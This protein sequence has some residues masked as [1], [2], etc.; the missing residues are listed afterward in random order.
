MASIVLFQARRTLPGYPPTQVFVTGPLSSSPR[1]H[2]QPRAMTS[3]ESAAT[4]ILKNDSYKVAGKK[5]TQ[6][7]FG[8]P[9]GIVGCAPS[10]GKWELLWGRL[11]GDGAA[12]IRFWPRTPVTPAPCNV[13]S[14]L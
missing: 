13:V 11:S 1:A 6:P 10:P 12:V 7:P 2:R 3:L 5:G 4:L 14:S 8:A 9:V